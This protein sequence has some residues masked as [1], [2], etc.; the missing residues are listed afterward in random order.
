M[1]QVKSSD[2]VWH[3]LSQYHQRA[4][5][6]APEHTSVLLTDRMPDMLL[7]LDP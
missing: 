6:S 4:V 2:K 7:V 3:L 5:L 1:L